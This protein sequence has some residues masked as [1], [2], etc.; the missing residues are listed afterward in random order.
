MP[1]Y[2][3]F[4]RDELLNLA[5]E[6]DQLTDEARAD[7]DA[8]L[9]I[10]RVARTEIQS[11]A[12]ETISQKRREERDTRPKMFHDGRS[13]KKL[14]G[15]KNLVSHPRRRVEEFD[16]TVWFVMGIPLVPLY[17]CRIRRFSRRWWNL[18]WPGTIHVLETR[19]RDW[20]QI[21]GTWSTAAVV[22][23][24]VFLTL[25][26]FTHYRQYKQSSRPVRFVEDYFCS[27]F[28]SAAF[29]ASTV[30]GGTMLF[31]RA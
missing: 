24:A 1:D 3:K 26:L 5:Q 28:F 31:S 17:S 8:E 20:R 21:F 9:S 14:F 6:R 16:T 11:Y 15:K 25:F 18:C 2:G 10:R 27:A 13:N 12:R 29:F 7:L 22:T 23:A 4:S 30:H 19:P